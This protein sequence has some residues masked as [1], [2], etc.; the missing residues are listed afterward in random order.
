[1]ESRTIDNKRSEYG[2]DFFRKF[3][4]DYLP[5]YDF[6]R[7]LFAKLALNGITLVNYSYLKDFLRKSKE[8]VK[9]GALLEDVRFYYN[10]LNYISKDIESNI[11]TLQ[12]LG[13]VGR[14]NPKYEMLLNYFSSE[15]SNK[16]LMEFSEYGEI[17]D[18]FVGAFIR[19][20]QGG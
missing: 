9:Y 10:G 14:S 7:L 11:N 6:F 4:K 8:D 18:S 20:T 19:S 12:T 16:L 5:S 1:M 15:S 3:S 13:A 2:D 17:L